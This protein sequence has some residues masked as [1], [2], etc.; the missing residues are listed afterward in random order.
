MFELHKA[1]KYCLGSGVAPQPPIFL[2]IAQCK[3]PP[4]RYPKTPFLVHSVQWYGCLGRHPR[5]Q[6]IFF[7]I[8]QSKHLHPRY[9][10]TP[11]LAYGVQRYGCFGRHPRTN[12]FLALCIPKTPFAGIKKHLSWPMVCRGMIVRSATPS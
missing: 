1:K 2:R 5:T 10:K 6:T 7:G 8:V 9:P 4:T 11:L 12:F 3:H